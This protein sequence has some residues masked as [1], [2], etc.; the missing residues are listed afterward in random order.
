MVLLDLRLAKFYRY[1]VEYFTIAFVFY[2]RDY[3]P[4]VKQSVKLKQILI[5]LYDRLIKTLKV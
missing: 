4:L 3:L 1:L 5:H 2:N